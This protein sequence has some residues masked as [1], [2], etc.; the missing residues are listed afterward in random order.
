MFYVIFF[1]LKSFNRRLEE[2]VGTLKIYRFA[3]IILILERSDIFSFHFTFL[4]SPPPPPSVYFPLDAIKMHRI[5]NRDLDERIS[6]RQNLILR[7]Q[8]L[9]NTMTHGSSKNKMR[10]WFEQGIWI[11][12]RKIRNFSIKLHSLFNTLIAYSERGIIGER[13]EKMIEIFFLYR[14]FDIDIQKTIA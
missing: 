6:A 11:I 12:E 14:F 5:L 3:I 13:R 4:L 10:L 7:E 9:Q 2:N 8:E 1:V